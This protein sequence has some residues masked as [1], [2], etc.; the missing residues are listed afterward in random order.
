[1]LSY[2]LDHAVLVITVERDP[3]IGGRADLAN[4]ITDLVDAHRPRPVVVVLSD[5]AA[6][7]AAVSAVLRAHQFCARLGILMSVVTHSA[8]L[9]R[10]LENNADTRGLRLVVHARTDTAVTSSFAAAA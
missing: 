5:E 10:M 8:P 7:G 3:G 4:R 9:R 1:M 6:G 2:R